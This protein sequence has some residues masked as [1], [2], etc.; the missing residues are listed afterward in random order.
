MS[1]WI[2]AL[3]FPTW[4]YQKKKNKENHDELKFKLEVVANI[5]GVSSLASLSL[6]FSLLEF[7]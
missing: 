4:A 7:R 3:C 6:F 1:D 5:V 2:D